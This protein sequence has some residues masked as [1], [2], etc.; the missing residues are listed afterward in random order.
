[1]SFDKLFGKGH[2]E[3][4]AQLKDK[5]AELQGELK[6][7]REEKEKLDRKLEK[8]KKRVKKAESEKQELHEKIN[9]QED[10]IQSLKNELRNEAVSEDEGWELKDVEPVLWENPELKLGKIDS[11]RSEEDDLLTVFLPKDYSIREIEDS[12]FLQFKLS[13]RQLERLEKTKSG[14]G[15]VLIHTEGLFTMLIK[16]PLPIKRDEWLLSKKFKIEPLLSQFDKKICLVFLSSGGSAVA[17]F[18]QEE[19]EDFRLVKADIKGRHSKGGFSQ[20]RFQRGRGE[21]VKEH[22]NNV[23]KVVEEL[24][25]VDFIALSGSQEM[26]SDFE[27]KDLTHKFRDKIFHKRL[28]LSNVNVEKDLKKAIHKFWNVEVINL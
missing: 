1:M 8:H 20:D 28:D 13:S 17:T 25:D 24:L 7:L 23:E 26:V 11:I 9:H 12:A 19:I 2:Q 15:K 21:E 6:R 16:P 10:Q 4:N 22:L 27:K 14:T 18:D 3:E 5:I